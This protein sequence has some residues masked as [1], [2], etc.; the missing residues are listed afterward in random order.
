MYLESMDCLNMHAQICRTE[1]PVGFIRLQN[2]AHAH[3]RRILEGHEIIDTQMAKLIQ[4]TPITLE[5]LTSMS[6]MTKM[7]MTT[8]M[9]LIFRHM[10]SQEIGENPVILISL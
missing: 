2:Q 5:D 10:D 7:M 3:H 1:E 8:M 9:I 6:I 4:A